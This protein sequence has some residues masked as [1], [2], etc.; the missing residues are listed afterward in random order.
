VR[1]DRFFDDLEDQLASE[2]EAERYA[3]D[4]EAERLRLSRVRLAERL[5]LLGTRDT[6]SPPTAAFELIDGTT[7]RASV[8]GAG[9]DWVALAE[10][11]GGAVIAPF[12]AILAVA[13]THTD[14]LRTARPLPPRSPLSDRLTFGFVLRDLVRRRAG[15]A[16]HLAS[17]RSLT[18]T[19]DRAGADHLDLA[20]HEPGAPRRSGAVVGYRIVPFAAVAWIRADDAP[21]LP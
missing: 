17:G 16:V 3:L 15:V 18:G 1:W 5:T 13:A 12:H 4:T 11:R 14:L 2:W 6:A 19:I 20:L 10:E 7:L 21:R 8:S 9:A